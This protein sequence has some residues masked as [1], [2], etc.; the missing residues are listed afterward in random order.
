[1]IIS[2]YDIIYDTLFED[3]I[4]LDNHNFPLIKIKVIDNNTKLWIYNIITKCIKIKNIYT[5]KFLKIMLLTKL[6]YYNFSL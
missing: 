1:M 2:I 3:L 6:H 4:L 5:L